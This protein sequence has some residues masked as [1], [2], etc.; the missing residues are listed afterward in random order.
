MSSDCDAAGDSLV[1]AGRDSVGR[2]VGWQ[3]VGIPLAWEADSLEADHLGLGSLEEDS[4]DTLHFKKR[5]MLRLVH[6][7]ARIQLGSV[8]QRVGGT[9]QPE[10]ERLQPM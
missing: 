2:E 9:I 8:D 3:V 6:G 5:G 7:F 1:G 4:S 10:R